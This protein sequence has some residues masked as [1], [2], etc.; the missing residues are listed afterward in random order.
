MNECGQPEGPAEA[1]CRGTTWKQASP[2]R[3]HRL[4][5]HPRRQDLWWPLQVRLSRCGSSVYRYYMLSVQPTELLQDSSE[6]RPQG[7]PWHLSPALITSDVCPRR[8]VPALR[9][10]SSSASGEHARRASSL[11][12]SSQGYTKGCLGGQEVVS[13]RGQ[14]GVRTRGDNV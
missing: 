9:Y 8:R 12:D 5:N 6:G 13:P 3:E 11:L 10:S 7:Q 1:A 2:P 4:Q 14:E